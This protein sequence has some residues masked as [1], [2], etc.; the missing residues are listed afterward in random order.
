M[1]SAEL[2]PGYKRRT[3]Y[4][5][6]SRYQMDQYL[7]LFDF[8]SPNFSAEKRHA[9]SVPLQRLFFMNSDFVQQQAELLAARTAGEPTSAARIQKVYRLL[10]GRAA[11]DQEVEAGLE[12]LKTEPMKSYEERK[13]EPPK[14]KEEGE[15]KKEAEGQ[16]DAVKADSMM[17]G[18][19]AGAARKP[20][21]KMLP[22]TPWGRYAKILLSSAGF[23]F[24]D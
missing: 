22:V 4:G 10:F 13:A 9:T 5:K 1:T 15:P 17:A 6:V 7:Q 21:E 16:P 12:F 11:S 3:V 2:T 18:V 8:P 20:E 14:K 24:V 23:V 19:T